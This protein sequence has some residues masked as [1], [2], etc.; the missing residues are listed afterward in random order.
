MFITKTLNKIFPCSNRVQAYKDSFELSS[1]LVLFFDNNLSLKWENNAFSEF[2]KEHNIKKLNS[3]IADEVLTLHFQAKI[4]RL[5]IKNTFALICDNTE[6]RQ[7]LY[8]IM[9]RDP[10]TKIGNLALSIK[11]VNDFCA[12]IDNNP[13]RKML[14]MGIDFEG[15]ERIDFVYGYEFGDKVL[16]DFAQ[17][18]RNFKEGNIVCRTS[19]NYILLFH[20]FEDD[21]F[22][23]DSYAKKVIKI[24]DK[25]IKVNDKN[26]VSISTKIGVAVLPENGK[27]R[28][29]AINS[30]KL[31][32][33]KAYEYYERVSLVFYE[34]SF[35]KKNDHML[36]IARKLVKK[37]VV[38]KLFYVGKTL[39]LVLFH[40]LNLSPL[41]KIQEKL[42]K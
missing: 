32:Q 7:S 19:G 2:K 42:C 26:K 41:L 18:L 40:L 33:Q 31:A 1:D 17:Q 20:Q 22:D 23:M 24:F 16:T 4:C 12:E 10:I 21:N 29:E 36:E 34:K 9:Y 37:Y 38:L 30:L 3:F 5:K 14:I 8:N 11:T 6:H 35:G 28:N 39:N 15:F 25:P 27:N 13:Q